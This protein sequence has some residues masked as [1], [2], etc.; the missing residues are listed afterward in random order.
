MRRQR[1]KTGLCGILAVTVLLC[2]V[3]FAA[4]EES[5]DA[6][7]VENEWNYA[8]G[9]IDVSHGIPENATGVLDR[10]KRKGVLKVGTE[11]YY[12]PL[13]F[14]DPEK[15][16]QASYAG[17]DMEL[18]RL[19][20]ER[21]GVELEIMPMDYTQVLPAVTENQCDLTISAILFTPG[22][23]SSYAMSKGYYFPD[24]GAST[25]FLIR[26]D[27]R[28]SIASVED[29]ADK[30][31]I[32]QSNS[33]QEALVAEHIH[34]YKEFRRVSSVQTIY[35]AVKSGKA[36]AGIVDVETAETYIRNNSSSG[37]ILADNLIYKLEEHYLGYRVVAKK[38][39]LQLIY[40]V[41]GVINEVLSD[42]LYE[43][44]IAD[45]QKRAD[46]LGL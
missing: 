19:I 36:D 44:W 20:A 23:A 28:E 26:E 22:R 3:S 45:A 42:G 4:A 39:E 13:E 9:S 27:N 37:L 8:D 15:S 25:G 38:S 10:I 18:A 31:L 5:W 24:S 14:I 2:A 6:I 29:L 11:P 35:E 1:I 7:Y 30:V 46:E 40:F 43:Q 17:A 16:G 12:A 34:S 32:A 33:L 41:N 21:M